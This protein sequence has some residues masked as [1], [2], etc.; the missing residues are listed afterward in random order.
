MGV[1]QRLSR[2]Y[3]PYLPHPRRRQAPKRSTAP[4][5]V[6]SRDP[7]YRLTVPPRMA[8]VGGRCTATRI[9]GDAL[10]LALHT[11]RVGSVFPGLLPVFITFRTE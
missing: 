4:A 11:H 9:E 8:L 7:F 2:D 6:A 3:P 1:A 5:S 10:S